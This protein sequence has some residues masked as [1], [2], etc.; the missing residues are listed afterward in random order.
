MSM[1]EPPSD[2]RL[3][4]LN[5]DSPDASASQPRPR[6]ADRALSRAVRRRPRGRALPWIQ[7]LLFAAMLALAAD[8]LYALDPHKQIGQYGHDS[9]TAQR[10]LPG[11]AVY[12][13]LQTRDGYL[14]VRTDAGL[15]RFDGVR[16]VSM[17]AEIAADPVR[18]ICMSADGDLLIRTTSRT[19]IYKDGRFA[20]YLPPATLPDG[21]TNVLFETR[22]HVLLAGAENFIY[23]LGPNG[24]K[25]LMGH[26]ERI[27]GFLEDRAGKTW[28][29]GDGALYAY[30]AGKL[31]LAS[32]GRFAGLNGYALMEDRLHRIWAGGK[33]GIY[34]LDGPDA[35]TPP[36]PM[37]IGLV[38]VNALIEDAQ[39]SFWMGTQ[40]QGLG[41]RSGAT[42][43]S[44][45]A[46]AGLTDNKVVA[47]FQDRE[48]SIWV[49]TTG[50]LDR[51]RDTKLTTMTVD[52]GLPNNN[53]GSVLYT[54]QGTLYAFC[55]NGGLATLDN[56]AFQAFPHNDKLPALYGPALLQSRDGSLW[57][58][59]GH[60]LT[61]VHDGKLT[62]YKGN[63][64]FSN[65]YTSVVAEDNEGLIVANAESNVYRFKDGK[66]TPFT[67]H[68]QT[69][70][71]TYGV[72][73]LSM[74]YDPSGVLWA[75][76]VHGFYK[77]V[78]GASPQTARRPEIDVPV[79]FFFDDHRGNL[80]MGGRFPGLLQYRVADGRV[81][82]YGKRNGLFDGYVSSVLPDDDGNL[83]MSTE[84][85]IYQ[86]RAKNLDDFA[87]NKTDH[88]SA[89]AYGLADGMKTATASDTSSQPGGARTPDG[90]LWFTT[91]KGL[92]VIDPR[93][94]LHNPQ[95]PGIVV[96]AVVADG[97]AR[98]LAN[99][100]AIP[101]GTRDIEFH[102]TA[103]SFR[104]P[105]RVRFKYRIEGYDDDWID[106]GSRR[107][108]YY[109]NLRPGRY[110]FH[111][112]AANDDG[113][114]NEQGAFIPVLIEPRFYQTW[115]FYGICV[116]LTILA[117][118]AG[119][120]INTRL[121]RLRGAELARLVE[122]KT[123]ELDQLAHYDALTS[124][125][126]RRMFTQFF[127]KLL[128]RDRQE[129]KLALLLI[130]FDK[131]KQ[132][133]DTFGHDAG[134]AFLVEAS[135]RLQAAIRSTDCVARLGGDEFAI[136]LSNDLDDAAIANVCNRI[137]KS[138]QAP[139]RFK[140]LDIHTSA[141]V[142]VA[143]S[144][145]HGHNQ[146]SLYKSADLA[147]Y[148]AKRAG[149]NNWRQYRPEDHVEPTGETA[150]F[151]P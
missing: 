74:Y 111:V 124:L 23:V 142:G 140:T 34:R 50:G 70:P 121:I 75:G 62:V 42:I 127:A 25:L 143:V 41:R 88:V 97:V 12:Q 119:N 21:T 108:A 32:T 112:I 106:A 48:G 57:V 63:G 123:R 15:A 24:P 38:H 2:S 80:W 13:I 35:K 27:N 76:T 131:F 132:I 126:N 148:D 26:S 96:E 92:V 72:Y 91:T 56:G 128:A 87:D 85:G 65:W 3:A 31:V 144:P 46:S 136:L 147:L 68:G 28:V 89:I 145:D 66:V 141:S 84:N 54:R 107:V 90:R 4:D 7:S 93:H 78:P 45:D 39:G 100:V 117:I 61:R 86:V 95:P 44:F 110:R 29:S 67:I 83:W 64:H 9:W 52:N 135:I 82:R 134:D 120:R 14:W 122:E 55:Y 18:A 81:T 77:F 5:L 118:V 47:L 130:D 101:P 125:A 73:V 103:L 139:V 58:G 36:G 146:E 33:E 53:L 60:A 133:N 113:V 150:P 16:F 109:S 116:L 40:G 19:V 71:I 129:N 43:S 114:W 104:V 69:T 79:T 30:A 102:Y 105:E 94:I 11:E 99:Q 138:F 98:P 37:D 1:I 51:F 137:M 115:L 59:T 149:R 20:D 10:G 6:A 49:G 8:P 151:A 17:D 22:E